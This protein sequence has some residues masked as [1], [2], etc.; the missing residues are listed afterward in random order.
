M[1]AAGL[2]GDWISAAAERNPDKWGKNM[3]ALRI[4]MISEK[5]ARGAKPDYFLVLP[6]FF[7]DEFLKREA[8]YVKNGGKMIFPLPEPSVYFYDKGEETFGFRPL[9]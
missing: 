5:E 7:R 3:G 1:Q 8:E 6:W 9:K 2:N 4:P